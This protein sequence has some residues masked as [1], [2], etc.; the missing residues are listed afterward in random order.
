M[1]SRSKT[2]PQ[3]LLTVAT[4]IAVAM[5]LAASPTL[6]AQELPDEKA[7]VIAIRKYSD[8][9]N[10]D[11]KGNVEEVCIGMYPS[12]RITPK[13]IKH[14]EGLHSLQSLWVGDCTNEE[15]K[16]IQTSFDLKRLHVISRQLTDVGMGSIC[17]MTSLEKLDLSVHNV[18]DAGLAKLGNLKNLRSLTLAT[19]LATDDTM[20]VLVGLEHLETLRLVEPAITD[21]GLEHLSKI[22]SLKHLDLCCV[23]RQGG[24]GVGP[25]M[26]LTVAP[27]KVTDAGMVHI[28]KLGNLEFLALTNTRIGPGLFHIGKLGKLK[29][30]ILDKT[31][32]SNDDLGHLLNLNNL[33]RLSLIQTHVSNKGVAPFKEMKSLRSLLLFQTDVTDVTELR[34][35]IRDVRIDTN[36]RTIFSKLWF[37]W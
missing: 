37:G 24:A 27:Q 18:A 16:L 35:S 23:Y 1:E 32:V 14:L 19:G 21:L 2:T 25:D 31:D 15:I 11:K 20:K 17:E 13:Y 28:A 29:E 5:M 8:W 4:G 9:V 30:L 12:R 7:D 3:L 6:Y 36:N 26:E 22:G 10:L 33:E 34:K